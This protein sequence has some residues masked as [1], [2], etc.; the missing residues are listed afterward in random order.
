[1]WNK[2]IGHSHQIEQLKKALRS[3]HL[4]NAYLFTGPRGVGKRTVADMVASAMVC[5]SAGSVGPVLC[6][7]CVPCLKVKAGTHP[8]VFVIEPES[9]QKIPEGQGADSEKGK[10]QKSENLKIEQM[11]ELQTLLQYHPL[12]AK[13]KV[14]IIDECD[15]MT[16]ATANSLLKILEEP[17]KVTHFIL[18]SA[19]PHMLLPTIR[20]RCR[21]MAFGPLADEDIARAVGGSGQVPAAEARRIARLSG[22][23]LGTA[24]AIDPD[25]VSETMNRFATLLKG[26]DNA[27]VLEVAEGWSRG[28]PEELRL[29]FDILASFYRDI[30]CIQALGES[31]EVVNDNAVEMAKKIGPRKAERAVSEIQAAR[32]TLE[33][34]ANKQ[35]MFEN[36]LFNLTKV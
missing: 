23:S 2:I 22:G 6:G 17:P 15:R 25:F 14:A 12:E 27:D 28:E 26:G 8:D 32:R 9:Q 24:L 36:L 19:M 31:V 34:T 5:Q 30:L 11:R 18:I 16:D 1:M 33:T 29:I 21:A 4:P 3:G 20:S 35:L 10:K 13:A 7:T